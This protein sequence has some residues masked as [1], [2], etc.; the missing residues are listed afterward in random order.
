[1]FLALNLLLTKKQKFGKCNSIK[2]N[3]IEWTYKLIFPRIHLPFCQLLF[4]YHC[5][6]NENENEKWE[7]QWQ[8]QWKW[9]MRMRM[10]NKNENENENENE[11]LKK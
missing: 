4:Y 8:W 11:Q 1:M 7:W 6:E 9:K 3:S 2:C 5:S 10:K